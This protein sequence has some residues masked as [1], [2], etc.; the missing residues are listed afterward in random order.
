MHKRAQLNTD[1]ATTGVHSESLAATRHNS[2]STK[3][4]DSDWQ[5]FLVLIDRYLVGL[6]RELQTLTE[7]RL[8][9]AIAALSGA[10]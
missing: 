6:K 4:T 1:I 8:S 10:A 3:N 7:T 9:T 5:L 2:A